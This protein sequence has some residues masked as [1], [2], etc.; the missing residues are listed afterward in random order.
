MILDLY[1]YMYIFVING[2]LLENVY[3][4]YLVYIINMN[5]NLIYIYICY[6]RYIIVEFVFIIIN[7]IYECYKFYIS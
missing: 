2:G 4:N 6:K 3:I 5:N 7:Y 1:I